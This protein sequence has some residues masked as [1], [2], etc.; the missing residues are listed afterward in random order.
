MNGPNVFPIV[1]GG[2]P[3]PDPEHRGKHGGQSAEKTAE[4]ME[5]VGHF[6][7]IALGRGNF[8]AF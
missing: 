2:A 6:G 3:A 8:S 7:K 1:V 4:E 5:G